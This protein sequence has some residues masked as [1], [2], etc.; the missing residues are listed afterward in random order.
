MTIGFMQQTDVDILV[1]RYH[2][3]HILSNY[4]YIPIDNSDDYNFFFIARGITKGKRDN[5]IE[6]TTFSQMLT[7]LSTRV[8]VGNTFTDTA[9]CLGLPDRLKYKAQ[10][11]DQELAD[12]CFK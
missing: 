4:Y 7:E 6:I 9:I 1:D 11:L 12:F 10:K 5:N 2:L 8:K 3:K